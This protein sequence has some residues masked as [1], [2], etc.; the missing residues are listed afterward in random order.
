LAGGSCGAYHRNG[1]CHDGAEFMKAPSFHTSERGATTVFVVA[2]FGLLLFVL[3]GLALGVEALIAQRRVALAADLA[4]LAGAQ[5]WQ[6]G[7]DACSQAQVIAS[8]NQ[9]KLE[10]C[11]VDADGVVVLE[12]TV[13]TSPALAA[14]GIS[15]VTARA[16]AGPVREESD[17]R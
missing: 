5:A 4:A 16:R 10:V 7:G 13:A 8:A 12:A 3:G 9:A 15:V 2:C 14:L 1:Y 6:N 11:T 17:A